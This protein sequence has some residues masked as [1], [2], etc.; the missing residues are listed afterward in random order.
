METNV[1]CSKVAQKVFRPKGILSIFSLRKKHRFQYTLYG[2][3]ALDNH[4]KM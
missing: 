4:A 1:W 2:V 3:L